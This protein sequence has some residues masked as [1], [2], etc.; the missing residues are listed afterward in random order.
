MIFA[1]LVAIA[2]IGAATLYHVLP[3]TK[4]VDKPAR[5]PLPD[6]F[7]AS[8]KDIDLKSS[9]RS[10][11]FVRHL[12]LTHMP[13]IARRKMRALRIR[14]LGKGQSERGPEEGMLAPATRITT[15]DAVAEVHGVVP[16]KDRSNT[17]TMRQVH[18]PRVRCFPLTELLETAGRPLVLNFGSYT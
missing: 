1:I 15:M 2:V 13:Q 9:L 14:M 5:R 6:E 10:W 18:E 11:G 17:Y 4:T 16:E 8:L 12:L 3:S 7:L